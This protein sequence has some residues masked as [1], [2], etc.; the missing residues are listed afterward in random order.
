MKAA[1]AVL[2]L[3]II[4]A[5]GLIGGTITTVPFATA[6]QIAEYVAAAEELL[7]AKV[8]WQAVVAVDAVRYH[9]D[10]SQA[11]PERIRETARLFVA[12]TNETSHET[13]DWRLSFVGD[14]IRHTALVKGAG[15]IQ[16]SVQTHSGRVRAQLQDS[17]DHVVSGER[18]EP[19]YYSL[20]IWAEQAPASYSVDLV[21]ESDEKVCYGRELDAVLEDLGFSPFDRE[22][23]RNIVDGFQEAGPFNFLPNPASP[24]VW[25]VIGQITSPFGFRVSPTS[26]VWEQHTGVDIAATEGAPISAADAGT[27]TYAG[28]SGNYGLLVRV[29]HA[30]FETWYGHLSRLDVEPDDRVERGQVLGPVGNTGRST[31]PHLHFEWRV[32]GTPIDPIRPY[33]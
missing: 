25:P 5:L 9:Q 23:A 26:G 18:V 4:P 10:F 1:V 17:L 13:L 31:G 29:Q 24:Y 14:A 11:T 2:L 21:V 30:G 33:Q 12:C 20:L 28:W 8:P 27:V 15:R 32:S 6:Q 3:A 22:M 19:G 7:P 16:W